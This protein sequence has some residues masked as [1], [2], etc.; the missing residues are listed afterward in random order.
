MKIINRTK[1]RTDDLRR[2]FAAGLK[3]LGADSNKTVKVGYS[4][5]GA[6]SCSGY[7]CY[8]WEM[9]DGYREG[10]LIYMGLPQSAD[11]SATLK[12][13]AQVFEHEIGHS[14]GLTHK[15]MAPS[16]TLEPIWHEDLPLRQREAVS[17]TETRLARSVA[18]EA[19]ARAAVERLE[20][21]IRR[22]TRLLQKWRARVRYY[23]RRACASQERR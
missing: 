22:K 17:V 23:E 6:F 15:E 3:A 7:A 14:Q 19:R 10:R 8:G 4:R 21:E 18:R 16:E 12:K 2:F 20:R 5:A 9:P 1:Y 11:D 13:I